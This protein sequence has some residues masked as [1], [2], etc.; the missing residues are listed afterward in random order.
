MTIEY[1]KKYLIL[2]IG[3]FIMAIG[4]AFSIKAD[5]G[6]TPIS[7]VPYVV[8]LI[9]PISVETATIIMHCT[10]I[11]AQIIL[12]GKNYKP[13]QLLQLSIA[14]LFGIM[15]DIALLMLHNITYNSYF[16]QWLLCILGIV[17]LA[18]GISLEVLAS[19][20]TNA[21]EGVVLAIC[22]VTKVHFGTMKVIFDVSLVSIAAITGFIFKGSLLGVREGTIAAAIFVGIIS[23]II[24]ETVTKLRH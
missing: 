22:K 5:L 10:F 18:L 3:L 21:G 24:I 20:I 11:A 14:L 16:E 4:I 1:I 12:L 2:F 8:S 19:V 17:L 6:T 7:C 23:K 9:S 13:V 15:T